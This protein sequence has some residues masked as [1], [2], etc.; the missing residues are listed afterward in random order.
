MHRTGFDN[1]C[2]ELLSAAPKRHSRHCLRSALNHLECA[3]KLMS[4]DLEMCAFRG[5]TA[6]EEAASGLMHCLK[7]HGY[8]NAE[9]LRPRDHLQKNAVVPFMSILGSLFQETF[10]EKGLKPIFHIQEQNGE[11]RLTIG[12]PMSVNGV[13]THAYPIPPLN[14]S[15]T[16]EAQRLSYKKE[17]A[18]FVEARGAKDI[19]SHIKEQANLRNTILYAGPSGYPRLEALE[20]QFLE[21]R[22]TR[23]LAMLRAYLVIFPYRDLQPFVQDGL[24][25]FLAMLG[26]LENNGLHS[27]V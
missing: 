4:V 20:P 11:R 26:A 27:E 6:E 21:L 19:I 12:I 9:K 5:L 25:A 10:G 15:V 17:I 8:E 1:N 13:D 2:I 24:D 23:V 16:S 3:D 18:R 7:E 22:Q 14:F